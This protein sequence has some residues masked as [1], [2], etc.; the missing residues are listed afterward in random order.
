MNVTNVTDEYDNDKSSPLSDCTNNENNIDI[1]I[2][3]LLLIFPCTPSFLCLLSLMIYTL[4]KPLL[5][6]KRQK[7]IITFNSEKYPYPIRPVMCIITGPSECGKSV[8]LTNSIL[9]IINEYD[10]IYIYSPSLHQ[11]LYQKLIK[12]FSNYIP[13]HII[14]N[15]LNEEDIEDIDIVIDGIV[16]NQGFEKSDT[17]LESY[18]SIEQLN[19]PQEYDDGGII[20]LDDLNEKEMNDPRVQAM[21]KRSRH[22]NLSIFIISQDYYEL[23]KK[24]IRAN[25]SIYLIFKPNKFLHVRNFF[26]DKASTYMTLD[27][28][29][30]LTSTCWNGKYQPVTIDMTKDCF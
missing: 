30:L 26:Q 14:T 3:L 17:E 13:I 7:N 9:N 18:E 2:P 23:P 29:N 24:T 28:F 11:D 15:I 20:I 19:Y 5:K 21:F 16:N 22:F 1:F 4:I 8:F 27:E 10:K 6:T 25:G 12:R